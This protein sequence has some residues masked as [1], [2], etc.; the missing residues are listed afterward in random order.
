MSI[1]ILGGAAK[2]FKLSTPNNLIRPTSVLLK[3]RFFDSMQ[4]F[5]GYEFVDLCAGS[6][7]IGLEA[8]S[9]GANFLYLNEEN[10]RVYKVLQQNIS[11]AGSI[12]DS[13]KIKTSKLSFEKFL[14]SYQVQ[15][16]SILF[17]DPPYEKLNLYQKFADLKGHFKTGII[18]VEF[19]R[20]KT[21]SEV[22]AQNLFGK[23]DRSCQQGTSF[24]YIYDL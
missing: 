21:M 16:N 15:E 19:C 8:L 11:N 4:N 5:A 22:E 3:R 9:R 18:V 17:F 7:A 12:L 23:P 2:G 24:L 10:S 20:Q 13:S 1:Q 6:G 14:L